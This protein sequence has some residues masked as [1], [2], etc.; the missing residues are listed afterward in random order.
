M[1]AETWQTLGTIGVLLLVGGWN[2]WRT[3]RAERAAR[4]AVHLSTPTGNGFADE[5]RDALSSIENKVDDVSSKA[6][7]THQLVIDHLAAHA[8]HDLAPRPRQ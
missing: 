7:V 4:K 5:V 6:D 8:H 2:G 3:I 1:D